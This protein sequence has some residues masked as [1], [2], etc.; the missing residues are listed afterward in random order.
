MNLAK[1]KDEASR[2]LGRKDVKYLIGYQR[3]SYGF[4]IAPAFFQTKEDVDR[5]VFS[6]LCQLSLIKYLT[7]EDIIP[8]PGEEKQK[9]SKIAILARGCDS[10][11]INQLIAEKGIPRD[12]LFI[13]GIPCTGVIDRKKI[14]AKF[15]SVTDPAD[16][17]EQDGKYTITILDQSHEVPKEEL[18]AETCRTCQ[19][20]TPLIYDKLVGDKIPVQQANYDDIT[21]LNE[22]PLEE[23]LDFWLD[24]F[25][26]CIRCYACKNACP[27]CYSLVCVLDRLD[28]QWVKRSVDTSENLMFHVSR[29][30]HLAGRCVS[31]GECE[32]ACPMDIPLMKLNRKL[33]KDVKDFF[34]YESGK[35]TES[36]SPMTTFHVEDREDFIL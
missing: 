16:V 27:L 2:A 4:R 8:Q 15:P 12:R 33:E 9:A 21:S 19:Y 31:C 3:G 23:K 26:R 30:F 17:I 6:P 35:D 32:R 1:L 5:L 29:A 20:P 36:R 28:P 25:E 11:A 13:I 10:R 18:L 14:E 22:K 34:D 24:Q 7:M